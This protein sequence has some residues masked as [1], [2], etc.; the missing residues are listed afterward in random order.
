MSFVNFNPKPGTRPKGGS[1]QDKSKIEAEP[2]QGVLMSLNQEKRLQPRTAVNW[3][4]IVL[5][6]QEF[7]AG[8]VMNI[9]ASGAFIHCLAAPSNEE[10]FRL[11][12]NVLPEMKTLLANAVLVRSTI[13]SCHDDLS[14]CGVGVR[15]TEA[16][17]GDQ[18]FF[19][20]ANL[21]A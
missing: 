21:F 4:C 18:E 5:I 11:L 6:P 15:F 19:P 10:S 9:S 3:P 20:D 8:E 16:F 2:R 14:S 17:G 1:P 12:I 7:I 13:S